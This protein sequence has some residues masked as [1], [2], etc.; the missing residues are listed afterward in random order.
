MIAISAP[1]YDITG[2]LIL[3]TRIR[4]PYQGT[5]RGSVTATLDGGSSVYDTG[6]SVSDQ[7]FSATLKRPT[8]AQLVTLRYLVAYYREIVLC[9]ESGAYSAMLSFATNKD[10][11]SLSMRIIRKIDE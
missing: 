1:T 2:H 4:N 6:Y 7:T 9:C 10:M 3:A 5:R 11:L 8:T